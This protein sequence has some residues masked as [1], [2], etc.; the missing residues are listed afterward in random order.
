MDSIIALSRFWPY[1]YAALRQLVRTAGHCQSQTR[2]ARG[3]QALPTGA[4][5]T[6]LMYG[7]GFLLEFEA[8]FESSET[9]G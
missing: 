7:D 1:R 2:W 8:S 6:P 4:G 5:Y 3:F 9:L